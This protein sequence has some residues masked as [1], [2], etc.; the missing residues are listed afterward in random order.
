[1][2][3]SG[4]DGRWGGVEGVGGGEEWRGW[5]V[6]GVEGVGGRIRELK[7][8]VEVVMTRKVATEGLYHTTRPKRRPADTDSNSRSMPP[9]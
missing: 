3:R 8:K 1:M 9:N 7:D 5:E 6:G 4:W 2:G